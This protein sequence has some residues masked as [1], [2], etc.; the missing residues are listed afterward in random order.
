M[1]GADHFCKTAE[2]KIL[3][4]DVFGD[5]EFRET[6]AFMKMTK[7]FPVKRR[8]IITR[9]EEHVIDISAGPIEVIPARKRLLS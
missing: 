3:I 2:A 1:E 5:T 4:G 9:C 8:I 6:E 7:E